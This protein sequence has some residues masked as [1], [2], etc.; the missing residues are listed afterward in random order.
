MRAQNGPHEG[1][2]STVLTNLRVLQPSRRA[3]HA[4][5]IFAFHIADR[6]FMFGR[7]IFTNIYG[8][9]PRSN[10]VYVY[11]AT[12]DDPKRIPPLL[13]SDLLIPPTFVNQ[14]PWT[15]GYFVTV[16]HRPLSVAQDLLPQHCF[17]RTGAVPFVDELGRALPR[18]HEPCGDFGVGNH[19]TI[20]DSISQALDIPLV[21]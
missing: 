14:K 15:L 10:L 12:S 13:C 17:K 19:R 7:L 2:N 16:A 4:G 21:P 11:R 8:P 6:P 9:A 3:R 1:M 20:D 5:D 18:R